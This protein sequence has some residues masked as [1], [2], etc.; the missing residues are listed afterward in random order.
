MLLFLSIQ[1]ILLENMATQFAETSYP[2]MRMEEQII[3]Y[4]QQTTTFLDMAWLCKSN[5]Q[6][7]FPRDLTP[8]SESQS[9]ASMT[10]AGKK[11]H[12]V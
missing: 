7:L 6:A 10:P 4:R 5:I 12:E 3:Q 11:Y 2:P 8:R 1:I 9:I